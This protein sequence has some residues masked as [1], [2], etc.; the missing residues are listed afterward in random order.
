MLRQI[1]D[2]R[3]QPF[4]EYRHGCRRSFEIADVDEA[5]YKVA[6]SFSRLLNGHIA[7]SIIPNSLI[8]SKLTDAQETLEQDLHSRI[9]NIKK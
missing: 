1:S 9:K 7:S 3:I 6:K 2:T 8:E 4:S 5:T